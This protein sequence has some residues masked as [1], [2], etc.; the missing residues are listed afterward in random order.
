MHAATTPAG[1]HAVYPQRHQAARRVTASGCKRFSRLMA[2]PGRIANAAL[3]RLLCLF[4]L[5]PS[6]AGL[7]SS[8]RPR[9]DE[10]RNQ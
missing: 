3:V 10:E 1:I 8:R 4:R 2:L 9:G 5:I 7:A 6:S